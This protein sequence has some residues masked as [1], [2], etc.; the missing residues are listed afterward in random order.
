MFDVR[1]LQPIAGVVNKSLETSG[2]KGFKI[3]LNSHGTETQIN[4]VSIVVLPNS[5]RSSMWRTCYNNDMSIPGYTIGI[6]ISEIST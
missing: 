5:I 6:D 4:I 2:N 1:S 3:F